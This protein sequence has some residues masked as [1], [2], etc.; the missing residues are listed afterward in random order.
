ML[1]GQGLQVVVQDDGTRVRAAVNCWA[2]SVGM[3][4]P[5]PASS[6]LPCDT[7]PRFMSTLLELSTN[8][9]ADCQALPGYTPV[10]GAA[11]IQAAACAVGTYKANFSNAA[12]T[13]CPSFT[14]TPGVAST[15]AA[16]CTGGCGV[17]RT[18]AWNRRLAGGRVAWEVP[19]AAG[20]AR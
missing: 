20:T 11:T 12:C 5:T 19:A 10:V 14:S 15:S 17:T 13:P 7:C 16:N 8:R 9:S 18:C 2:G 4:A 6:A 1:R 3:P